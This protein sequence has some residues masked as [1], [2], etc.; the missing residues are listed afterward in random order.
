MFIVAGCWVL[1]AGCWVLVAG[2]WLLV[3]LPGT[4]HRAP[5]PNILFSFKF[6][7][8]LIKVN[9]ITFIFDIK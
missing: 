1:G 9:I 8:S 6:S 3:F 4:G 2:F 5:F 7:Y